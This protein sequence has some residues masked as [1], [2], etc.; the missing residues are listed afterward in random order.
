[1]SFQP[2]STALGNN[3]YFYRQGDVITVPAAGSAAGAA[4]RNNKPDATDPLY[5][6]LDVV[7]DWEWDIKSMGD[8]KVY[9]PSPGRMQLYDLIEKGAEAML[10]FSTPILQGLAV[11]IFYR[12]YSAAAGGNK[13][14]GAGGVFN[15]LTAPPQYGWI[16]T[17]LYDNNN[18]FSQSLDV[19]GVLRITGGFASKD[20]SIVQPKFEFNVLYSPQAVGL[21]NN[22]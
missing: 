2:Q 5:N 17:E 7:N 1:M 19:Y 10:K 8:E 20:G 16:H 14:T 13:I 11:E 22:S 18:V 4:T 15:P 21:A 3:I 6:S 9:A 12:T